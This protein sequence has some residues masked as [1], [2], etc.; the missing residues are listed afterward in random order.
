[1]LPGVKRVTLVGE[2][3]SGLWISVFPPELGGENRSHCVRLW[4]EFNESICGRLRVPEP[5]PG[6]G[7]E[8][9]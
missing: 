7:L 6:L 3:F 2:L 4:W 5:I 9:K 1:M 8:G